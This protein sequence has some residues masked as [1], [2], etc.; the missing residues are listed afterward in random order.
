MTSPFIRR[1][2][3]ALSRYKWLALTS[4]VLCVAGSTAIAWQTE[5]LPKYFALGGLTANRAPENFTNT[6]KAILEQGKQFKQEDLLGNDVINAVANAVN[7]NPLKIRQN[8]EMRIEPSAGEENRTVL[9]VVYRDDD[10]ERAKATAI[11]LMEAMLQKSSLINAARLKA[12]LG[13][14]E[15]QVT[16]AKEEL[17]AAEQELAEYYDYDEKEIERLEKQVENKKTAVNRLQ[18]SLKDAN[19]ARNQI[20]SSLAIAA[21][22]E[23]LPEP[24]ANLFFIILGLGLLAGTVVSGGLILILSLLAKPSEKARFWQQLLAAYQGRCSISDCDVEAALEPAY[25][26]KSKSQNPTHAI[27]LRADL[28]KL[29]DEKL[30]AIDPKTLKVVLAPELQASSYSNLAD[31][32][33]KLPTKEEYR[34][35][36]ESLESHYRRCS[37]SSSLSNS[38]EKIP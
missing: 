10:P 5:P 14:L 38:E 8:M 33:L 36:I 30:L 11:G 35:N 28:R 19:T 27:V 20:A 13:A 31:R 7:E 16:K 15:P 2:S 24:K 32:G 22:P 21:V 23:V 1:Y 25:L 4:F 37:W 29:F 26:Q 17:K 9:E 34:P 6:A 3:I 12:H 18:A